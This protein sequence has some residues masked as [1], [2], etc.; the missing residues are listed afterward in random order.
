TQTT[1]NGTGVTIAALSDNVTSLAV[2]Q[3]RG[4]LPAVNVV[5]PSGGTL[6][7][8]PGDE[9]TMMLEEIHAVAP[10]ASLA[11]CAPVTTAGYIG[12]LQSLVAAG[13]T[14][15]VDDLAW[16]N[17]D[18]LSANSPFAQAVQAVLTANPNLL[19]FTVTENYNGS[20]W[21]GNY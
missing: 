19:L 1:K 5:A 12:C 6:S 11:F 18:L 10:G 7:T 2:I 20:Y 21:E 4:E 8:T 13:A 3:G 14:I 16:A 15:A 9:G 17:E